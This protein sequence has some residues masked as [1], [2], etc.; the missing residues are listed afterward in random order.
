MTV[1]NRTSARKKEQ[2]LSSPRVI[3]ARTFRRCSRV[4]PELLAI[5]READA[6]SPF[7]FAEY[8]RLN[9]RLARVVARHPAMQSPEILRDLCVAVFRALWSTPPCCDKRKREAA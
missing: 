5:R 9:R 2:A 8:N 1:T 6:L 7:D 3:A 4:A